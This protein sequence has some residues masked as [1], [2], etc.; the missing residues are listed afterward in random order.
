MQVPHFACGIRVLKSLPYYKQVLFWRN[1][2][3]KHDRKYDILEQIGYVG[4]NI[5][6]LDLIAAC[7]PDLKDRTNRMVLRIAR[8]KK[9]YI[10]CEVFPGRPEFPQEEEESSVEI[11]VSATR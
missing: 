3:Q 5:P 7:L 10:V 8:L 1:F 6:A 9:N 4:E 2:F 11:I